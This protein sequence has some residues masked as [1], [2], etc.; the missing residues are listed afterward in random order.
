MQGAIAVGLLR[1]LA[2]FFA[3]SILLS[4]A[5]LYSSNLAGTKQFFNKYYGLTTSKVSRAA[6]QHFEQAIFAV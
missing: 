2:V 3:A 6:S 4:A 1:H 5:M